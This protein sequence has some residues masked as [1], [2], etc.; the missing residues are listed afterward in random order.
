M[1][2]AKHVVL[3]TANRVCNF[4]QESEIRETRVELSAQENLFEAYERKLQA[5]GT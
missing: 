1:A 4:A 5:G 3:S 2:S